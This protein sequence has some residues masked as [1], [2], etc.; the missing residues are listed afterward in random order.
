MNFPTLPYAHVTNSFILEIC[1]WGPTYHTFLYNI[2][3]LDLFFLNSSL[4]NFPSFKGG[5]GGLEP[6]KILSFLLPTFEGGRDFFLKT[7]LIQRF[8]KQV[9]FKCQMFLLR[10]F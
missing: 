8:I 3:L 6:Q 7:S 2:T 1:F 5:E 9:I 10:D 4:R